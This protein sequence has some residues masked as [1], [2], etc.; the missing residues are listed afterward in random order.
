LNTLEGA[1]GY[2]E[3]DFNFLYLNID[4]QKKLKRH[5][6]QFNDTLT[7]VFVLMLIV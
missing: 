7:S 4:L 6:S 3:N 1:R 5:P 2:F